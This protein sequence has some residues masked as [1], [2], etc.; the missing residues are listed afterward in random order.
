MGGFAFFV[1]CEEIVLDDESVE[2][3]L[4]LHDDELGT[5]VLVCEVVQA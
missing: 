5:K 3:F 1:L 4:H 2:W